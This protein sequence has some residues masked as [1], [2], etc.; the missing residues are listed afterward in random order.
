MQE[1]KIEQLEELKNWLEKNY[2]TKESV[3]LIFPKKSTGAN[4]AWSE[5]VDVLLCYG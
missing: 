2:D 5:I 4:F 1:L 3:W